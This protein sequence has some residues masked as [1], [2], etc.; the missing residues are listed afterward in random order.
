[1]AHTIFKMRTS[2]LCH[3]AFAG[4]LLLLLA[5]AH[6]AL[7]V[8]ACEPEWAALIDEL[9][10]DK[11]N[12]YRATTAHQDVHRIQARPSLIAQV[13][14]A[15]LVICTGAELEAGW[16]PLLLRR[17]ANPKV[18]P[19]QAGYFMAAEQVERLDIH[20]SVD[21]SMGDVHVAGN[22]HIHLDPYRMVTIAQAL[23]ERL[24]ELDPGHTAFYHL[25]HQQFSKRWRRA[26]KEW[27]QQALPLQ[28]QTVV[29]H[30][31]DWRYLLNWLGMTAVASL[32]PKPGIPPNASH[33]ARLNQQMEI[34]PA[35]MILRTSYQSARPSQWLSNKSGIPAIVLP[36][37]VGG[38]DGAQ[39][40]FSLY[41]DTL[42][43]LLSAVNA[44]IQK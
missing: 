13:R 30:H 36:Y 29:V 24:V 1:M 39:D 44:R 11:A 20:A 16:L 34:A 28:R 35:A 27:Q 18:Q 14:K 31:K 40:L 2:H 8:F 42:Q 33:L 38:G 41:D 4:L 3:A 23:T 32:E 25:Q 10:A 19:D 7:Q 22:P 43:R 21:R 37:T 9:A 17:A 12:V 26:I 5:P 6:A 15:D